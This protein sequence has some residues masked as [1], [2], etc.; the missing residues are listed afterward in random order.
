ML[1]GV[2]LHQQRAQG[3]Q[4]CKSQGAK[5]NTLCIEKAAILMAL[6]G[7]VNTATSPF[8]YDPSFTRT[9][10]FFDPLVERDLSTIYNTTAGSAEI[11]PSGVPYGFF[12]R[13]V[14]GFKALG[15][16]VIFQ[17]RRVKQSVTMVL[18]SRCIGQVSP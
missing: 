10:S 18:F 2:L 13:A 4:V 14:T 16:P 7:Q 12:P 17:V 6:Q 8:G 9:S 1:G 5:L 3:D 15:F 11:A